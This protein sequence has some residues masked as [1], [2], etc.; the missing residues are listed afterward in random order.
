MRSKHIIFT[1]LIVALLFSVTPVH[2]RL[3]S[4]H[5]DSAFTGSDG[6]NS[7]GEATLACSSTIRELIIKGAEYFF[8]AHADINHLRS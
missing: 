6:P 7:T 2:A 8:R 1:V 5:S 4:N 3:H